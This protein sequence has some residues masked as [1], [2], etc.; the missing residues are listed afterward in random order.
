MWALVIEDNG[1]LQ[2]VLAEML[3]QVGF[4]VLTAKNG[5]EALAVLDGVMPDLITVDVHIPGAS[6]LEILQH[7]RQSKDGQLATVVILSGDRPSDHPA[8]VKLADVY[9]MKPAGMRELIALAE[10]LA[11][12]SD[13]TQP[14]GVNIRNELKKAQPALF[15]DYRNPGE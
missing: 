14:S 7:I 3:K 6:C 13:A 8:E 2:I 5:H 11:Q 9:L 12:S 1:A 10:R 4:D 15:L